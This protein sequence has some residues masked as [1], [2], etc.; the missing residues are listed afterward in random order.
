MPQSE[1]DF[2]RCSWENT[3]LGYPPRAAILQDNLSG[4]VHQWNS[5]SLFKKKKS[6]CVRKYIWSPN[7]HLCLLTA[8]WS[9]MCCSLLSPGLWKRTELLSFSKWA[10]WIL[11]LVGKSLLLLFSSSTPTG[12][13]SVLVIKDYQRRLLWL[14]GSVKDIH[15]FLWFGSL[16]HRT[17]ES[18]PN[19]VQLPPGAGWFIPLLIPCKNA[20]KRVSP[21][22]H[23]YSI[24]SGGEKSLW[25][26]YWWRISKITRFISQ[27]AV[28]QCFYV[29]VLYIL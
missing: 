10:S 29:F 6:L 13:H 11:L 7:L 14:W 9:A 25:C 3:P 24:I 15:T 12:W 20:Q 16:S 1:G 4:C 8:A 26:G 19:V 27:N 18:G 21:H 22:T 17:F 2:T 28:K 5:H 23:T